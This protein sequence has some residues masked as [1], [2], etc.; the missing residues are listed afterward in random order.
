MRRPCPQGW[1]CAG[2]LNSCVDF[3]CDPF[4]GTGCKFDKA[5]RLQ[6]PE[7]AP[8]RKEHF[9]PGQQ[10]CRAELQGHA[11]FAALVD[12]SPKFQQA[13]GDRKAVQLTGI[14]LPVIQ[15]NDGRD[16]SMQTDAGSP[17]DWP[18][19]AELNI[20]SAW[21]SCHHETQTLAA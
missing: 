11:D 1:D 20:R 10:M 2:L 8:H 12:V 21:Q 5:K 16:T 19:S 14:L 7:S 17:R 15:L 4:S 13:A 3:R 6:E 18:E 9:G